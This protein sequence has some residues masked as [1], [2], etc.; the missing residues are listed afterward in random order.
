M[1]GPLS[2]IKVIELAAFVA[3]PTVGRLMADMGADVIKV[4]SPAG[5]GWRQTGVS[6]LPKRFNEDENPIFDIYNNGKKF[7]CLDLK[8]PEGLEALHKLLADADVFLT[9]TR[10]RSLKKLGLDY[11]TLSQKYPQLI[12]AHVLGYGEKGP[13]KDTPAFDT[14]AFWSRGGFL[15]D[16]APDGPD[17]YPV[18][19]PSGVGDSVTGF[20]LLAEINSALFNRTRTGKGDFVSSTLFHNAVFCFGT[21]NLISQKPYGKQYPVDRV[22]FGAPGGLYRCSDDEWV[23]VGIVSM[24]SAVPSMCEAIGLPELVNDPTLFDKDY[25]VVDTPRVYEYLKNAFLQ[26]DSDYWLAKAKEYDFP[27]VRLNRY[28]NVLQDPQAVV[29]GFVEQVQFP[30]GNVGPMPSSPIEMASVGELKT[31]PCGLVGADTR[32]VLADLGYS[33]KQIEAMIAAGAAV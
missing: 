4:E 25:T 29:N 27:L 11:E 19:A 15:R 30:N 7:V 10:P 3:A 2:G 8:D 14:T 18:N 33:E 5:D 12:Y 17:Y 16:L 23:Y 26:H 22:G 9:N 6:Y 20:L 21:M 32:K 13:E 31:V 24:A 28:S 1:S